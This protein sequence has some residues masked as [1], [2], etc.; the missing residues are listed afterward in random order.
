M[1][2]ARDPQGVQ[3]GATS[4]PDSSSMQPRQAGTSPGEPPVSEREPAEK[5]F[6][7]SSYLVEGNTIL[8][9]AKIDSVL[10]SYKGSDRQLSDIETARSELEKTYHA[11]GYPTVVVML[12]EQTIDAGVV[13]L[14]VLEGR[15]VHITVT[16]NEHY[17]WFSIRGK[18]PSLQPGALIYEPTFVKELGAVNGNPDLK[19]APVLK[20]GTEPG[21]VDL[22]LKV[23]DRLPVHGKLEADNRGPITTP[24][25]RLVAEIQHTNLFGGDEI[26]TVNT[27]QT[28]TDWGAVQ[29]YGASFVYPLK[30]P[31]HLLAVYAYRSQSS[32]VLAGGGI[33]FGGGDIGLAGNATIAG[34]RYIFP[35][36]PGGVN[37]HQ[38]SVGV[39]YKSLHKTTATFPDGGTAVVLNSVQY[40]PISA[41]Y[42][43]FYPD[44]FGLTKL[45]LSAK[46]Y[47]AGMIPGGTKQ[48]FV[49]IPNDPNM[50]GLRKGTTGTFAVLQE[51]LDRMQSLPK[52]FT[53]TLHADGQWASQPL[54]PA[55]QYFAG[56]FDTVRGYHQYEA[57]ADNAVRGRAELTTPELLAIPVDRLWQR[58]RSSDYTLRV[59][60]AAFYDAAQLW[61]LQAS[62][63][64]TS[65]FRLEGVGGGIRV[66][67]PKDIGQLIIDQGFALRDTANTKRGDTFVHFSVGL[68]F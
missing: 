2:Q 43:G 30:W 3:G 33:S 25:N 44:H 28:P 32:S 60:F 61:V 66:K 20:P 36:F 13:K 11:A 10:E 48:D 15:L 4:T 27:V 57:I 54:I 8:Q 23:K 50:P 21:T 17:S 45:A 58:R 19:V 24:Q 47:V 38:L 59:R 68:A 26:F 39:D 9:Q 16:G 53:L 67:F 37:T 35:L 1:A 14:Q 12:P 64:Q 34:T 6:Q 7:I 63:G 52:D 49:G 5:R 22:E 40:T 31:D 51:G 62:P 55:E 42:T 65:Q 56:G 46:G 18:L 41:G 29:N